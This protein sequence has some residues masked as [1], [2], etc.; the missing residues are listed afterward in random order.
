MKDQDLIEVSP[1][2]W[3]TETRHAAE[4]LFRD[5]TDGWVITSQ[6]GLIDC[7]EEHIKAAIEVALKEATDGEA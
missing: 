1:G 4:C 7:I 3:M 5:L 2:V 6:N